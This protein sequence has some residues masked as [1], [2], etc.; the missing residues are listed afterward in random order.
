[1]FLPAKFL[2]VAPQVQRQA[3]GIQV[4]PAAQRHATPPHAAEDYWLASAVRRFIPVWRSNVRRVLPK[5]AMLPV[6]L[7]C[8]VNYG[9]PIHLQPD[10]DKQQFLER[11]RAAVL[12]LRPQ[13]DRDAEAPPDTGEQPA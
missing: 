11:A 6:P 7:A 1:M 3:E 8:S 12:T 13:P 10:E 9:P 2:Q 4:H 5:G